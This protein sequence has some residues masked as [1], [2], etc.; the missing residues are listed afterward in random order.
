V[1]TAEGGI[2]QITIA[3]LGMPAYAP[4]DQGGFYHFDLFH[5]TK[6]GDIQF[7]IEPVLQSIEV[8]APSATLARGASATL[9]AA[10]KAV[11]GDNL[12]DITLPIAD[13]ASH[14]WASDNPSVVSVDPVSGKV[15]ARGAGTATVSVTSGG[16]TGS[17]KLTVS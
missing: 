12:P 13:P 15:T 17:I 8:T 7:S 5:I 14:V 16:V 9:S 3:D 11:G 1:T 10:G 4:V 6:K 2:P